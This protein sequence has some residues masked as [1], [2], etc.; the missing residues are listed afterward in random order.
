M[1]HA[2]KMC[3]FLLPV[4]AGQQANRAHEDTSELPDLAF[5]SITETLNNMA[6]WWKDF[7]LA[8]L[9]MGNIV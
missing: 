6:G 1:I 9:G 5:S 2:C 3:Y 7:Y 4:P 8:N